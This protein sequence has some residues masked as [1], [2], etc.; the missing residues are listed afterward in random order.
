MGTLTVPAAF[1][2][3]H[4]SPLLWLSGFQK[5]S[6]P[7]KVYEL[8]GKTNFSAHVNHTVTVTGH[9]KMMSKSD[10]SKVEQ[11]EKTEAGSKPYADVHVTSL[12]MVSDSCSP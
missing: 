5:R 2:L 9:Q 10:E 8:S 3:G 4:K 6:T 11:D 7:I 12:K 1:H